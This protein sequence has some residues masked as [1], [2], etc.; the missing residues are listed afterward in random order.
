MCVQPRAWQMLAPLTQDTSTLTPNTG[1]QHG[2]EE[3]IFG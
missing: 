1:K 2:Q 3:L